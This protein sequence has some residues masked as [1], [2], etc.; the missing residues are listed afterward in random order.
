MTVSSVRRSSTCFLNS[1][2]RLELK[3]NLPRLAT[4][5]PDV[6]R[7]VGVEAEHGSAR[8]GLG[9]ALRRWSLGEL[10]AA[11]TACRPDGM[12]PWGEDHQILW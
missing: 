5:M 11:A 12:C 6:G 7:E 4:G 1:N 8:L 2:F 9:M 10:R 3:H